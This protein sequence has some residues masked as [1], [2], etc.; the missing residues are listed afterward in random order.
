MLTAK[1]SQIQF[2]AEF[3]KKITNSTEQGRNHIFTWILASF[4]DG[5]FRSAPPPVR[6][7]WQRLLPRLSDG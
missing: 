4:A 3:V 1:P 6:S 2:K 7:V 5:L